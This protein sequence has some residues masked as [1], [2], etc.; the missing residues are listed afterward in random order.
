LAT[1][2]VLDILGGGHPPVGGCLSLLRQNGG[3]S[4]RAPLICADLVIGVR[5]VAAKGCAGGVFGCWVGCG[6]L[7]LVGWGGCG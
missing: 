1:V 3:G 5:R 6:N 4:V 2:S 7:V